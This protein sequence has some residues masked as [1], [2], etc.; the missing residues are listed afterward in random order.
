MIRKQIYIEPRQ[1]RL[2]KRRARDLGLSEAELIRRSIDS[3]ASPVPPLPRSKEAWT[4]ILA[5]VWRH[6]SMNVPQTG[7]RWTRE[8]LYEERL[9]RLSR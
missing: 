4:E 6:R 5:Y 2:L 8:E 7:R 3:A 9:D 1:E